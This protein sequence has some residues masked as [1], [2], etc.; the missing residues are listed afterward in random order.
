MGFEILD[1][2][3]QSCAQAD[4]APALTPEIWCQ[5][6]TTVHSE[7][8]GLSEVSVNQLRLEVPVPPERYVEELQAFQAWMDVAHSNRSNP[9]VVRAQVMT[10]LYVSFVWLRD[11]LMEPAKSRFAPDSV[12]AQVQHFLASGKRKTLRNAIAHGRW[13]YQAGFGGLECW[14]GRNGSSLTRT[15]ISADELD[16]W[17]TLSRGVA[18]AALLAIT[19]N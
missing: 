16:L 4:G 14:D 17:Q 13:C 6:A 2:Q 1:R 7:F 12:F 18:I 3:L 10:E 19:Q 15:V 8:L 9:V 5:L 11:S